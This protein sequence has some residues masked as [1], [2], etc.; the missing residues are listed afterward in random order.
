MKALL[1][2]AAGT[3]AAFLLAAN[4]CSIKSFDKVENQKIIPPIPPPIPRLPPLVDYNPP[5]W[6]AIEFSLAHPEFISLLYERRDFSGPLKN[7]TYLQ[8]VL[9]NVNDAGNKILW[10]DDFLN[11]GEPE[12]WEFPKIDKDGK[13]REDC[14][15]IALWKFRK[16]VE[17]GV[18]STPLYLCVVTHNGEGHA[19]LAVSTDE[20]DFILDNNAERII[21]AEEAKQVYVFLYRPVNGSEFFGTWAQFKRVRD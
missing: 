14:D 11:W 19:V 21:T 5:P 8:E 12:K 6:M 16:L 3:V 7:S 20:G 2:L 17:L 9:D 4:C 10:T 18:P 13:L 15:G 1:F